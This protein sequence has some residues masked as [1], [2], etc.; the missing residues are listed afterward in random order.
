MEAQRWPQPHRLG[1][2]GLGGL[3]L[4]QP[5][6]MPGPPHKAREES[7]CQENLLEPSPHPCTCLQPCFPSMTCD[8][9]GVGICVCAHVCAHVYIPVYQ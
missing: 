1:K 4:P 5:V 7:L 9:G 3:V 2:W 8:T 6:G